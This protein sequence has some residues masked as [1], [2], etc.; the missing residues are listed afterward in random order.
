[1][2]RFN[3]GAHTRPISTASAEAQRWFDLGLNWCFGFNK[4]EGVKCCASA[5]AADPQCVMAYWGSA[6]GSGP[7]YNLTWREHGEQEA[8]ACARFGYEQLLPA[9]RYA[10]FATEL[11]NQ[12]VEALAH[13]FQRPHSVQPEEY[14]R[15]D[16]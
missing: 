11:E 15:W 16:D 6:F 5:I 9:R 7:F 3:L 1:M 2:D 13:R 14:D 12:L 4:G 10:Q 8:D